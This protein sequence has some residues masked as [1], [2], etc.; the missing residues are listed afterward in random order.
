MYFFAS[1]SPCSQ[2]SFARFAIQNTLLSLNVTLSSIFPLRPLFIIPLSAGKPAHAAFFKNGF[3]YV[4]TFAS[5]DCSCFP[6]VNT[7]STL[8]LC[9]GVC[10]H[11]LRPVF[12]HFTVLHSVALLSQNCTPFRSAH[13]VNT[14]LI[15]LTLSTGRG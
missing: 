7:Y 12:L 6:L 15:K 9:I 8:S 14:A 10:C 1:Q 2:I 11:L 5:E 3:Q 4:L 13:S